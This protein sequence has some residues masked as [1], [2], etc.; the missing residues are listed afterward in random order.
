VSREEAAARIASVNERFPD[1]V[2]LARVASLAV[3]IEPHLIRQLRRR[4]VRDA[5]VGTE[6]DLWFSLLVESRGVD[7][8]VLHRDVAA[9]L[10][11]ELTGHARFDEIVSILVDAHRN[12][13]STIRLEEKINALAVEK[14]AAA[15][16]AI[17]LEL[18]AA[19]VA[20]RDSDA[21]AR[22]I[23]RWFLR[24]APRL[25]PVVQQCPN[26][27]A[28]LLGSSMLLGRRSTEDVRETSASLATVG[29]MLPSGAL[30]ARIE[31]GI[32][33]LPNAIRFVDFSDPASPTAAPGASLV[34]LSIPR[35]EPRLVEVAWQDNGRMEQRIVEAMPGRAVMLG[36]SATGVR[37]ITLAGDEYELVSIAGAATASTDARIDLDPYRDILQSCVPVRTLGEPRIDGMAV[38]VHA[39][40]LFTAREPFEAES[41]LAVIDERV[42][43][44]CPV[45]S[46]PEDDHVIVV[47]SD[48]GGVGFVSLH[49]LPFA[50]EQRQNERPFGARA[51][52]SVVIGYD[53]AT[54]RGVEGNTV[55][56]DLNNSDFR[57][58]VPRAHAW[59]SGLVGGPV[60][61]DGVVRGIVNSV[62]LPR[63]GDMATLHVAGTDR[64]HD[65]LERVLKERT[66]ESAAARSPE[67]AAS[68]LDVCVAIHVPGDDGPPATGLIVAD[69]V[70][71]SSAERLRGATAVTVTVH[72][73]SIQAR[74]LDYWKAGPLVYLAV[75]DEDRFAQR[76]P[77][78]RSSIRVRGLN[79]PP[80]PPD[81]ML[82]VARDGLHTVTVPNATNA[83]VVQS[84]DPSGY[85]FNVLINERLGAFADFRDAVLVWG[86]SVAGLVVSDFRVAVQAA[87]ASSAAESIG[88]V[89][90]E[91]ISVNAIKEGIEGAMALLDAPAPEPQLHAWVSTV[92]EYLHQ[93]A[94]YVLRQLQARRLETRRL[95]IDDGMIGP[96]ARATVD[97]LAQESDLFIL[98]VGDRPLTMKGVEGSVTQDEYERARRAGVDILVFLS[99]SDSNIRAREFRAWREELKKSHVVSY[100]TSLETFR[101]TF[102]VALA[103]W[104]DERARRD[105]RAPRVPAQNENAPILSGPE[106]PS[107]DK[108][109]G[110]SGYHLAKVVV[111]GAEYADPFSFV[112]RIPNL[113]FDRDASRGVLWV[114][115]PATAAS[116][117]AG[118]V[119]VESPFD[120]NWPLILDLENAALVVIV[121]PFDSEIEGLTN[122]HVSRVRAVHSTVPI[123]VGLSY[124]DVKLD[125]AQKVASRL[126]QLPEVSGAFT[127]FGG[128]DQ[129]VSPLVDGIVQRIDWNRLPA[130][131]V[132]DFETA[133]TNDTKIFEVA[134]RDSV[135]RDVTDARWWATLG[136]LLGER[137]LSDGV[138][139]RDPA[140]FTRIVLGIVEGAHKREQ[141]LPAVRL[142]DVQER[143][144]DSSVDPA[145]VV[146]AVAKELV[147]IRL[148]MIVEK[149]NEPVVVLPSLFETGFEPSVPTEAQRVC[150]AQWTGTGRDVFI[151]LLVAQAYTPAGYN[152]DAAWAPTLSRG[153]ARMATGPW[154]YLEVIETG[155]SAELRVSVD[156]DPRIDIQ[157]IVSRVRDALLTIMRG[158]ASLSIEGITDF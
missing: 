93:H 52:R 31:V 113:H 86:D 157:G 96:K 83:G 1:A 103:K 7:A 51:Q 115:G 50:A 153:T 81:A 100:F 72:N 35:S 106:S 88:S 46:T 6:A 89:T 25:H 61:I 76:A 118:L 151:E 75:A 57:V 32:E 94:E 73:R 135:S 30:D 128:D 62:N 104:R 2:R 133:R 38:R 49:P 146:R 140:I 26:A 44:A 90:A 17:D 4:L 121:V 144:R 53:G 142:R 149:T 33:R 137:A 147:R 80:D 158:N 48:R 36:T 124:F 29:W 41:M 111:T 54:V 130:V 84:R 20:M 21:R 28:L 5:D 97:Q 9:I 60:I 122:A 78:I 98:I 18:R 109:A 74:V 143:E 126:A 91:F 11:D 108:E 85:R 154:I 43:V 59:F 12:E 117:H 105:P 79:D 125:D 23:A 42:E 10:R 116:L 69:R 99:S 64:V 22:E 155:Q 16:G 82:V 114:D 129:P 40:Y 15:T 58:A 95:D 14:G 24:A 37:V 71:V 34:R 67:P 68:M 56:L 101:I 77:L 19:V 145:I 65:L 150:R 102:D 45:L 87:K 13:P 27:I 112:R 70:I 156:R 107:Q 8:I 63:M 139:I 132:G 39:Q 119:F 136:Q 3:R 55:L 110:A 141:G 138:I 152:I 148:A 92:T 47:K 127:L 120:E 134:S 131:D 123:V 66:E